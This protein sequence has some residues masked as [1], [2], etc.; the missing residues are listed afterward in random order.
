M[1]SPE[2]PADECTARL[3]A[4]IP[5]LDSSKVPVN[6]VRRRYWYVNE[7]SEQGAPKRALR[8]VPMAVLHTSQAAIDRTFIGITSIN[9]D[10]VERV[11]DNII[12]VTD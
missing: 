8:S 10:D 6:I 11:G 2:H 12:A 9:L 5:N 7:G 1:T 4:R 3:I